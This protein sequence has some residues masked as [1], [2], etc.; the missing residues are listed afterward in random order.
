MTSD[1]KSAGKYFVER[2]R[3]WLATGALI[4]AGATLLIADILHIAIPRASDKY[5]AL[6]PVIVVLAELAVPLVLGIILTYIVLERFTVLKDLPTGA[7]LSKEL[8]TKIAGLRNQLREPNRVTIYE[9]QE[10]T[11]SELVKTINR[12]NSTV[13]GQKNIWH[14]ILHGS[15]IP[16]GSP[17]PPKPAHLELFDQAIDMCVRSTG[18]D[19]WFVRQFYN[20]TTLQRLEVLKGRLSCVTEGFEVRAVCSP[21]LL[22]VFSPLIVSEEDA[23]LAIID[24]AGY[25]VEASIHLHGKQA[26]R[27]A[28]MYFADLWEKREYDLRTAVGVRNEEVERLHRNIRS[29]IN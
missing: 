5:P 19:R 7:S 29:S 22:P 16:E 23:F 8:E 4:V 25:R 12:V 11:Y 6:N 9:T 21:G 28:T 18:K 27:F 14:A 13:S 24:S 10:E 3:H 2:L 15:A 1:S 26:I 17:Q 20:V